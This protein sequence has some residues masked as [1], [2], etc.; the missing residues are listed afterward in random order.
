[1]MKLSINWPRFLWTVF[2]YLY[3]GLFFY[4]F[5]KVYDNWFLPYI[6]TMVLIIWLGVEY[7]ENHI[8]FQSPFTPLYVHNT[9][10]RILF[11]VFFY[12]SFVIGIGTV[13]WWHQYQIGLYP[14]IHIIGVGALIYSIYIRR[15]GFSRTPATINEITRFYTS[16]MILVISMALGYGSYFLLLYGIII[17]LPLTYLQSVFEKK[18]LHEFERFAQS[19]QKSNIEEVKDYQG[20]WQTYL[21]KKL[22]RKAD[23]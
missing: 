8:F 12:S 9:L 13:V 10:L 19:R 22:K 5:F 14:F 2:I 11:A 17:G 4:N 15:V 18:Q 21:E 20:L 6:Y 1:M 23:D 16:I 7:Y 3:T